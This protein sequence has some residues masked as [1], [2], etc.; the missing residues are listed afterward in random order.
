MNL[1]IK[2][3]DRIGIGPHVIQIHLPRG[4]GRLAVLS[5]PR[6]LTGRV[7]VIKKRKTRARI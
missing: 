6:E 1:K 7:R 3:G 4:R 2:S 5:I